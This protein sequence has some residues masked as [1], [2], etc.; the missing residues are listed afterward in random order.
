[1]LWGGL[2]VGFLRVRSLGPA[3]A[4]SQARECAVSGPRVRGLKNAVISVGG[5]HGSMYENK[6]PV[7][8]WVYR[9]QFSQLGCFIGLIALL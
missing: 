7:R 6:K 4:Q 9:F 2:R 8:L 3:S 5:K 1:M